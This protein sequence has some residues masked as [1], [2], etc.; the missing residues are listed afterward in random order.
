MNEADQQR[1]ANSVA[2]KDAVQSEAGQRFIRL[3]RDTVDEHVFQLIR[4]GSE[5]TDSEVRVMVSR[6]QEAARILEQMGDDIRKG[7]QMGQKIANK[8]LTR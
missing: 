5:K 1:F 7:L 3:L 2:L 4:M 6:L 8:A